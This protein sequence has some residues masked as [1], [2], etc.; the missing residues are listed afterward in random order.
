MQLIDGT[1]VLSASDL[2]GH[3][4]CAHLT[5]LSGMKMRRE[6]FV[7][8]R[9]DPHADLIRR[10]GD[11]HE[12][13]Y[14]A[15]L[16]AEH[17]DVVEIEPPG[18]GLDELKAADART[19]VAMERG[20]PVIFQAAFFDGAW[21]GRADFLLR[22]DT[23]SAL[24]D[25][26]YEVVDT[27]LARALKATHVHQLCSY[28]LHVGRIQGRMPWYAHIALGN[29]ETVRVRLVD[30]MPLHRHARRRLAEA[31]ESRPET[32]PEPVAHCAIC[33][34]EP[35]C[36]K[37]RVEDDHLSLVAGIRRD[38]RTKLGDLGIS[39]VAELAE[40][41]ADRDPGELH[42]AAF[43]LLHGQ[44]DLQVLTRTTRELQRRHLEP[45]RARGYARLPKPDGSDVFFDLEGDPFLGEAGV[46]YLWGYE[47]LERGE[48]QYRELWA[49][50]EAAER[51]VFEQ[52]V[53]W[54]VERR[55]QQP[56]MRLYHY[57]PHEASALKRLAS[58]HGSR[59][60][61]V[62]QLL[63][64]GAFVD[65]YAVVR[66]GLQVGQS[67]Y[68]IKQ[69]EPF[70]MEPR[71]KTIT[72][73]GGSIVAYEHWI[74][75]G[76][77]SILEEIAAYN[78]DDCRSNR[79]L[80][81]WLLEL[82]GE[83]AVQ[84]DVDFDELAFP[85]PEE[86]QTD[87]P[88]V[89]EVEALIARLEDGLPEAAEDDDE[90]AA[91]RRMLAWL[92]MYHRRE[93]KP[94]W[95]RYFEL[96]D[97]GSVDLIGETDAIGGLEPDPK[98]EPF[99]VK[100]ST[101]YP[102]IF[103]PQET[104]LDDG[105][106][107]DP[108]TR[109]GAGRILDLDPEGRL[110]LVRGARF[111]DSALPEA[112]I[113]T[114]AYR[115]DAQRKALVRAGELLLAAPDGDSALRSI[116]RRDVPRLRDVPRG[117]RLQEAAI[118]VEDTVA[119]VLDLEASHL[120]IQGPPGS[121]KT[122]RGARVIVEALR[123]QQRVAVCAVS[124]KAIHNMLREVESVA[125]DAGVDVRGFH[126]GGGD[127][128]YES[129]H[130]FIESDDSNPKAANPELNLVSGTSWLLSRD[131]QVGAY[132]L[133]V[134]DEAGQMSLADAVAI[135]GCA[136]SIALLGDPQ[137][138][139]QVTQGSHP[140]SSGC[141]VLEHLLGGEPTIPATRGLFLTETR[142]MHPEI[143]E[144]ISAT[145]Y[146][147]RLFPVA[148]LERRRIDAPGSLTGAGLRWLAVEH[149]GNTQASPEEAAV[150]AAHC[151]ELL[152]GALVTDATGAVSPL[153]PQD[154]LVVAPYNLAVRRIEDEVPAGVRV[155]TVDK[156]QGQEAPVVFYAMSSSTGAD[157]PRGLD[158][159][160]SANRLNVA[161]SR[162][163]CLAVLVASP[164]LLDAE[165]RTF[166]QMRMVSNLCALVERVA[167]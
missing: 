134:I 120:V 27:K 80:R 88:W 60:A 13:G 152:G 144:Y 5:T 63:R 67:S 50:D 125:A 21:Q 70:Y 147:S 98:R 26:S 109:E 91:E 58:R 97:T 81:D 84:F 37:R 117:S 93:A 116:L 49:H 53:D 165:C 157:A 30:V 55:A 52:F 25:W 19:R 133:L 90:Q 3:L 96:C 118:S 154:I 89:P 108:V 51:L 126:K 12:Q 28:S 71:D 127:A 43:R 16:A 62:D 2:T 29:G 161:I 115:T 56:G 146:E 77:D 38:Q 65:L 112:L 48:W 54:L 68:S 32:Y 132:N 104:R 57:A 110:V 8:M 123:R 102:M 149:E 66:Q 34:F 105:D 76:E 1:L 92:L 83:A 142:R 100:R 85:A 94:Q 111:D 114:G 15:A 4:S 148:G 143:T 47:V 31:V 103:P 40:Q 74:D 42:E 73:G 22:A 10:R 41:P 64:D 164:T 24:G 139:P 159:L 82:R 6:L 166:E 153:R 131:E 150:I 61:E 155:G 130:G 101:G 121:G 140:G 136:T 72:S 87:P 99:P 44:A 162:A 59:E 79:L 145:F 86:P 122:Y 95:W 163:Q 113:E 119:R 11:E 158:F 69:I 78:W 46:E 135:T 156:F 17:G 107:V 9:G 39:T 7:P 106:A 33:N 36:Y 167:S 129:T 138:L 75:S 35:H 128:E 18:R 141:S 14:L 137:Q 23:P 45:E 20:A 124:H 160:F 151:R